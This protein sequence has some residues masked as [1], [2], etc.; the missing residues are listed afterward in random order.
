MNGKIVSKDDEQPVNI[1]YVTCLVKNMLWICSG[2]LI[3][4][5]HILTTGTCIEKLLN[6]GNNL[7]NTLMAFIGEDSHKII[8]TVYHDN[9]IPTKKFY[10]RHHNLRMA[11][12]CFNYLTFN[13]SII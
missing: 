1:K 10:Q 3:S 2:C 9:Y 11:L 7:T 12:V 13:N 5:M 8:H 4:A 6:P